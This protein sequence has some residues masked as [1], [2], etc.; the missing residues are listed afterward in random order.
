MTERPATDDLRL[1]AHLARYR[2]ERP[3]RSRR[4][5]RGIDGSALELEIVSIL[6]R[7]GLTDEEIAEYFEDN[8][9]PRYVEEKRSKRWLGS[10]IATARRNRARFLSSQ[11]RTGTSERTDDTHTL[12]VLLRFNTLPI[13]GEPTP[14]RR[15]RSLSF[16][17]RGFGREG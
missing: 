6:V 8:D 17:D 10:L 16:E 9:L 13:R 7:G 3:S 1:P 15:F 11:A 14:R 12:N 2:N 5:S 4:R